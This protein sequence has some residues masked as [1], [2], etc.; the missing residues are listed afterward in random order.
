MKRAAEPDSPPALSLL[1]PSD[2]TDATDAPPETSSPL[3]AEPSIEIP[4]PPPLADESEPSRADDVA[5][6]F[7]RA[8]DG[9]QTGY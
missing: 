3:A 1:A 9:G 5:E 6:V 4:P 2:S 7:G 8:G